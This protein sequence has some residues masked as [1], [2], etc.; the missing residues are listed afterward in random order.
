MFYKTT[1]DDTFV[2]GMAM[3]EI[4]YSDI[5]H[6]MLHTSTVVLWLSILSYKMHWAT[7][8]LR[9]LKNIS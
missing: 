2:D 4:D 5:T 9:T 6:A 7:N 8:L 1:L 3:G